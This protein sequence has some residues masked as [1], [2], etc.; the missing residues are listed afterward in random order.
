MNPFKQIP[1]LFRRKSAAANLSP[2]P[3]TSGGWIPLIRESDSGSWQ[4]DETVAVETGLAHSALFACVS[5]VSNDI[6]KL[7]IRIAAKKKG[8]WVEVNHELSKLFRKPNAYQH[9]AQFFSAWMTS[10]LLHGNTYALK[11]RDA[12]GKVIALHIIDPTTVQVLISDEDGA[13]FYRVK[14]S[15]LAGIVEDITIPA[16]EVIH[17]R[18]I[19]PFHPLIGVSPLTAASLALQQGLAIQRN[20][21]KFFQNGARPGGVLVAPGAI[22]A[23][24][25]ASLK[26]AWDERYSGENVGKV[27]VL[28]DGLRFEAMTISAIDAQLIEQLQFTAQDVCRAFNVPAWKIGAGPSAPYTSNEAMSLSYYSDAV[29]HLVESLELCLD[30]GLDLPA[31]M[32]VEFDETALLRMDTAS[33]YTAHASAINAGWMTINEVR[34]KEGLAPVKG[35]DEVYRQLQD[36][37]LS[38]EPTNKPEGVAE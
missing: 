28:G 10:K 21:S 31:N 33:R 13:V 14:R 4:R 9:R 15:N 5:L 32:R 23:E 20:A 37:P 3:S 38:G 17:D 22:S 34:A 2:A 11:Q 29:Q 6:A 8:V 1:A 36:V 25:A 27:A 18:H 26:R 24:T 30:D 12:S 16:R 19:T 7:P 35:G